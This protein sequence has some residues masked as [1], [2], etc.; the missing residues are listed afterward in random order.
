MFR[1]RCRPAFGATASTATGR[2]SA[3]P[4]T[5]SAGWSAGWPRPCACRITLTFP[6]RRI[7]A[8]PLVLPYLSGER[9][10]GWA[11]SARATFTGVSAATTA[12]MLARGAME[13]VAISYARIAGQLSSAAGPPRHVL[14]SGRITKDLPGLLQLLADVLG[15]PVTPVTDKRTTLRGTAIMALDVLAPDIPK[16]A[17]SVGPVRRPPAPPPTTLTGRWPTRPSTTRSSLRRS[18][19]GSGHACII[20]DM[21]A[22]QL[23]DPV[24]Y[25]GEGPVWS[26]RWGGLRW[27]DVLADDTLAL[28]AAGSPSDTS[29]ASPPPSC[30]RSAGRWP[31]TRTRL[32]PSGCGAGGLTGFGLT[33]I[34]Y[35]AT[36]SRPLGPCSGSRPSRRSTRVSPSS[37]PPRSRSSSTRSPRLGPDRHGAARR[38]P[39]GDHQ[40]QRGGHRDRPDDRARHDVRPGHGQLDGRARPRDADGPRP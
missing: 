18:T 1:R 38:G 37:S 29:A 9:S 3:A 19:P 11:A 20:A 15:M 31:S 17:P 35:V 16:A 36:P 22:E 28:T 27:V 13:G 6:L 26:P 4:S 40:Q 14:A 33:L 23:T 21:R 30:C 8:A 39:T 5:T 10:T 24:A 12:A 25:H 2:C 32:S 7:R 34:G